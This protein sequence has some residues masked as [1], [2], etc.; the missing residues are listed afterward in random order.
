MTYESRRQSD[1]EVFMKTGR[2]DGKREKREDAAAMT[3]ASCRCYEYTTARNLRLEAGPSESL[4]NPKFSSN[5]WAEKMCTRPIF[6]EIQI[7][8]KNVSKERNE[9]HKKGN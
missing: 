3:G 4:P 2:C 1:T 6:K 8:P 7:T 5:A 9:I